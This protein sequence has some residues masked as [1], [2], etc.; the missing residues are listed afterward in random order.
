MDILEDLRQRLLDIGFTD[1]KIERVV[2][3]VR[4]DWRGEQ[5]YIGPQYE[6]NRRMSARNMQIIRDFKAGERIA[7]LARKYGISRQR[8]WKIING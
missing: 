8:V 5:A 2:M 7:F 6:S 1:P 3:E 4:N